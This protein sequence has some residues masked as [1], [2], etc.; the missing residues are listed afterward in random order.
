MCTQGFCK[1]DRNPEQKPPSFNRRSQKCTIEKE[2]KEQYQKHFGENSW[3]KTIVKLKL[4]TVVF[5]TFQRTTRLGFFVQNF[6]GGSERCSERVL[7]LLQH[8]SST[9][10]LKAKISI[11][12]KEAFSVQCLFTVYSLPVFVIFTFFRLRNKKNRK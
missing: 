5:L 9:N 8:L 4:R 11:H 6:L 7:K 2:S 1:K 12:K 3:L 10:K